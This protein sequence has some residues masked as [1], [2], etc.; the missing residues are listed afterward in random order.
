CDPV[1]KLVNSAVQLDVPKKIVDDIT[2]I[3]NQSENIVKYTGR[4]RVLGRF[5]GRVKFDEETHSLTLY[6]VQKNDSGLYQ[7]EYSGVEKEIVA[8]HQIHVL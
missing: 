2:W 7:A 1:Y 4:L 3:F 8:M 6:S 5:A